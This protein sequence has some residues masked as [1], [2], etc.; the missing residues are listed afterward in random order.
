MTLKEARWTL[1]KPSTQVTLVSLILVFTATNLAY[2]E[3]QI[4]LLKAVLGHFPPLLE[5]T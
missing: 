5:N 2:T 3:D 4:N 1:E